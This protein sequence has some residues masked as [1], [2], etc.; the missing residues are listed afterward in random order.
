MKAGSPARQLELQNSSLTRA[1]CPALVLNSYPESTVREVF[2]VDTA[3][4]DCSRSVSASTRFGC[5]LFFRGLD[6][7]DGL[8]DRRGK[9]CA[10][11]RPYGVYRY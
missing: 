5:L 1:R 8:L 7:G 4:F 10:Q 3:A 6:I 2:R 9:E 11:S